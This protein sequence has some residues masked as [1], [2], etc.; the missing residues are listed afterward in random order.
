MNKILLRSIFVIILCG[1][2]LLCSCSD[3]N[4]PADD[5]TT[6]SDS[7]SATDT[8]SVPEQKQL[9]LVENG[10]A[11]LTIIRSEEANGGIVDGCVAFNK[12]INK[13][14]STTFVIKSDW[15]RDAGDINHNA[16]EILVGSTNRAASSE[17]ISS[18]PA[19][20]YAIKVTEQQIVI[21]GTNDTMTAYAMYDFEENYL[22]NKQYRT[23]NGFAIPVGTDTLV[24]A[25]EKNT[26]EGI[27]SSKKMIAA[28]IDNKRVQPAINGFTATQ[29]AAT[30]GTYF[31]IVL[32]KNVNGL[33][34]DIIVKRR[35]DDWSLVAVSEELPL[36][37]A[38]DMCYNSRENILV[39]PS[40]V[41]TTLSIIDPDTLTL[42]RQV[43]ATVDGTPYAIA[44]NAQ[45]DRYCI[46]AGG[47]LNICDTEFKCVSTLDMQ[48]TTGYI[49][50]GMDADD[51]YIYMP[52][53][54]DS[55]K[56][57]D[58]N[59]IIVYTWQDGFKR[60][61]HLATPMESETLMNWEGKYY[62]NFNSG[63]CKIYDLTY[64]V[65]YQ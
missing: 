30:D 8:P 33:E 56:G 1:A 18:L 15:V 65:V 53:S 47:K 32:K 27:M 60:I 29:G 63:G 45:R 6:P 16:S 54:R 61:V 58:D 13:L 37:H 50:Q 14:L 9:H 23:D 4:T 20:S 19:D 44:Y 57:T 40:M 7:T 36:H 62:I 17:L 10:V 46:A 64:D 12:D 39:V 21:A 52:L 31:Y 51:T 5:D 48:S 28:A 11:K 3:S 41:G 2:M 55:S 38:N 59:I 26:F 42:L 49:G 22:R 25:P 34:T 24:T 43:N 35:M